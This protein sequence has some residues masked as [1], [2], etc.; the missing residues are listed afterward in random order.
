MLSW[1]VVADGSRHASC[2]SDNADTKHC[3]SAENPQPVQIVMLGDSITKGVRPGVTAEETFAHLVQVELR[4]RGHSVEVV[5][6]GIGGERTDQAVKR[7]DRDVLDRKPQFVAIMYGTNDSYV[8]KGANDSRLSIDEFRKHLTD[9]VARLKQA[10][11]RPIV[12]TEPRWGKVARNGLGENPNVRLAK[13]M[14][15]TRDVARQ[16]EAPLVDHFARWTAREAEGAN[17]AEWTT[18]QCHPNPAG[19]KVIADL[20]VPVIERQLKS[21]S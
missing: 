8:D 6:V 15:V 12:M 18:D 10:G 14:D 2:Q 17:I 9:I 11:V 5:N 1:F 19:H 13:F 21:K 4:K 3:D 20:I 16:Q 7:L